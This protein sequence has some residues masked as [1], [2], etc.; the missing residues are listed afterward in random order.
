MELGVDSN[1]TGPVL[2]QGH[3]RAPSQLQ[4][5]VLPPLRSN[6][7]LQCCDQWIDTWHIILLEL[8]L[9]L[10]KG[11]GKLLGCISP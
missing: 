11:K 7:Y 2:F 6:P 10:H 1:S 8:D 5:Q 9:K 3:L 4:P